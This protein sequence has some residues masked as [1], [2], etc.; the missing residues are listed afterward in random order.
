MNRIYPSTTPRS[1]S[2]TAVVVVVLVDPGPIIKGV[3]AI[4]SQFPNFASDGSSHCQLEDPTGYLPTETHSVTKASSQV[5]RLP[6]RTDLALACL[7]IYLVKRGLTITNVI[8]I[9][10]RTLVEVSQR[11]D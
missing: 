4:N 9:L 5:T 2:V 10:P 6:Q 3:S 1:G 7:L 11:I 8:D